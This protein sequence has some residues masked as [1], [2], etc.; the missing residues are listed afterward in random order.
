MDNTPTGDHVATISDVPS[1][2]DIS[3]QEG[4]DYITIT[5]DDMVNS[6]V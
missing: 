6:G 4:S 3:W 2:R 1:V 5:T